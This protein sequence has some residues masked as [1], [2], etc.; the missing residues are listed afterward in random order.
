[1]TCTIIPSGR[2]SQSIISEVET[3]FGTK[4]EC[5]KDFRKLLE[6]N[7]LRQKIKIE[8]EHLEDAKKKQ[9]RN[10]D[11]DIGPHVIEDEEIDSD[12]E[13]LQSIFRSPV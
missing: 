6:L 12:T 1:M 10:N 7:V 4:F 9:K 13:E 3:K 5:C 11:N 2:S 8:E